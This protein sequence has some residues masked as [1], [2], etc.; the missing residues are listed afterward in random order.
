MVF[1][2]I[3]AR[4]GGTRCRSHRRTRPPG[5]PSSA[6]RRCP[7]RRPDADP[8]SARTGP[9][10]PR[11]PRRQA[12]GGGAAGAWTEQR[13]GAN[14]RARRE[15]RGDCGSLTGPLRARDRKSVV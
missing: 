3:V 13:R 8:E 12:P 5:R 1:P 7:R 15:R 10:S 11:T 9:A 2:G 4:P 14:P 6:P